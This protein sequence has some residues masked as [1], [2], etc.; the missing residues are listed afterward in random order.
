M[1]SQDEFQTVTEVPGNRLTRE[2]YEMIRSRYAFARELSRGGDVFEVA[3]GA[4][5]GLPYLAATARQAFGGDVSVSLARIA[6]AVAP[7]RVVCL[8]GHRIPLADRSLDAVL[9]LEAIYYLASPSE[10]YAECRR[11]LRPGGVLHIGT[12]NREWTDFNPSPYSTHYPSARELRDSLQN[13]GFS[14]EVFGAFPDSEPSASA[15]LVSVIKRGAVRFGLMPKTMRGKALLKRIFMGPL[16]D[17][18]STLPDAGPPP[19]MPTRIPEGAPPGAF[20]I[21]HAVAR[22]LP[23]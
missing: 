6:S 21:L 4:G 1:G 17:A 20:K 19:P 9:L 3:C 7:G 2:G 10:F 14:V 15:G 23:S 22:V 16:V 13:A 12:V 11:V 5:Q 18:P 8:D